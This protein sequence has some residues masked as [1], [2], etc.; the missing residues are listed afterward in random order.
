M[1]KTILFLLLASAAYYL[2]AQSNKANDLLHEA[3]G[4]RGV[5]KMKTL[6][7]VARIYLETDINAAKENAEKALHLANKFHNEIEQANAYNILGAVFTKSSDYKK[8]ADHYAKGLKISDS[9]SL[10]T[11]QI[12]TRIKLGN[13]YFLLNEYSDAEEFL[14]D[15]NTIAEKNKLT[16]LNIKVEKVFG[17]FYYAQKKYNETFNHFERAIT[18]LRELDDTDAA[19]NISLLLGKIATEQN[20]LKRAELYYLNSLNLYREANNQVQ[21]AETNQKISANLLATGFTEKAYQYHTASKEIF[22]ALGD[23]LGLA[24]SFKNEALIYR[25]KGELEKSKSLLKK[26]AELLQQIAISSESLILFKEINSMSAELGDFKNA[27]NSHAAYSEKTDQYF[28]NKKADNIRS[29]EAKHNSEL[30]AK[31]KKYQDKIAEFEIT[32]AKKI[33]FLLS[34]LF[35]LVLLLGVVVFAAYMRKKKDRNLLEQKS[36]EIEKREEEAN[37]KNIELETKNI[38]LDLLNKKLLTE[39]SEREAIERSSFARDRFLAT[40]THEMRNPLNNITALI[41]LLLKESPKKEQIEHLRNLQF[42]ANDLIVFINDILDYSKIEAGKLNLADREFSPANIIAELHKRYRQLATEND[43]EFYFN[44]DKKIPATLLGDDARLIQIMTNLLN[45]TFNQN[46]GGVI[47]SD[48][49]LKELN[50]KEALLQIKIEG[51]E[52]DLYRQTF[53]E[54]FKPYYAEEGDFEPYKT[55]QFSLAITKRLVEL[56]N[57]KIDI[58][59]S[60]GEKAVFTVLLPFKLAV[61]KSKPNKPI[62]NNNNILDGAHIL[63]VEDNKINQIVVSKMLKRLGVKVTLA[64]NG[65]EA[66]EAVNLNDFDPHSYGHPNAGNGWLSG[67][68]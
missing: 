24:G 7:K 21:I 51:S 9:L 53:E 17:D 49:F 28:E 8:A 44:Y 4:Q 14:N 55:E 52:G 59:I 36:E 33:G 11:N 68:H 43:L 67:N 13:V 10:V 60:A 46:K 18:L 45:N 30:L 66:V 22:K 35:T 1:R 34:I 47:R 50:N 27:Y 16:H 63:I 42:S 61:E 29:L 2:Y 12:G 41:H 19:A 48:V 54:L 26:G 32:A 31:E 20:D 39:I 58:E 38:S 40:M 62:F 57:G 3:E 37:Y 15:A 5:T 23:T 64:N 6:N 65:I 25:A 56:Q